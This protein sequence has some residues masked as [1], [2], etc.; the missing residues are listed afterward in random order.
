MFFFPNPPVL[1]MTGNGTRMDYQSTLLGTNISPWKSNIEDDFPLV[2][3]VLVPWRG[4]Y[5]TWCLVHHFHHSYDV[6]TC[7]RFQ[8]NVPEFV[9]WVLEHLGCF[10][11]F[12]GS[13]KLPWKWSFGCWK[14]S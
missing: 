14:C 12:G 7:C 5:L 6:A 11:A 2:G 4:N 3:Y 9:D 10:G 13:L 1:P 8:P